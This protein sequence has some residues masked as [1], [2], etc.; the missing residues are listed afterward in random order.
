[1]RCIEGYL[2]LSGTSLILKGMDFFRYLI[3]SVYFGP[4]SPEKFVLSLFFGE[5]SFSAYLFKLQICLT[6]IFSIKIRSVI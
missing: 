1:M 6:L 5:P 4:S 2:Q 3:G